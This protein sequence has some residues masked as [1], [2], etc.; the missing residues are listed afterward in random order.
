MTWCAKYDAARDEIRT[1]MMWRVY[2]VRGRRVQRAGHNISRG[3]VRMAM[4]VCKGRE[5]CARY[6]TNRGR[7]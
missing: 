1:M 5:R 3:A 2:I 7:V 4:M 6:D